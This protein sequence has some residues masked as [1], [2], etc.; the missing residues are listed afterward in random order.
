MRAIILVII[1]GVI[2]AIMFLI[3][4]KTQKPSSKSKKKIK[5]TNINVKV[6]KDNE[7]IDYNTYNMN[8]KE[9]IFYTMIA[10]IVV[11]VIGY[12]FY[13]SIIMALII[14]PVALKYPSMREK[15]IIKNQKKKLSIQFKEALYAVSSSLSAGKSV[16]MA[17]KDAL[18]DLK[19]LYINPD[20][21]IL[22]EL[23]YIIRRLELNETIE[24]TL[25]DFKS[26][27]H[28]EDVS[29]FVDVFVICKR[30]GG[31]LVDIIKTTS[32]TIADKIHI[33]QDIDV[34]LSQKKLE[35][36][37]LGI[38]PIVLIL[39]LS[40]SC[41][42]YMNPVFNTFIGKVV[43]TIAIALFVVSY[44]LAVKIINIEV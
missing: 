33:K 39:L 19:V 18:K 20:T 40:W 30:T 34:M 5:M 42:E 6:N 23:E 37:I 8:L 35:Q 38:M 25:L 36:K 16:E 14:T 28:L 27:A 13:R 43:I 7:L 17:F 10:A 9:K 11:F 31:D 15:E 1:A 22:K 26:R 29:N 2:S 24:N 32:D 4:N 3:L 12:V 44:F 21:F 41:P